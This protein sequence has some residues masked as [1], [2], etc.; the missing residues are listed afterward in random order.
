MKFDLSRVKLNKVLVVG[1]LLVDRYWIG[2]T[3]KISP[4][5]PVPVVLVKDSFEK[6]GGAGNVAANVCLSL[7]HI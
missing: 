2:D 4:E 6:L 1:D 3:N 5:A 7:I